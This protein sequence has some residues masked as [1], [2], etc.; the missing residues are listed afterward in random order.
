MESRNNLHILDLPFDVLH[1]I[2]EFSNPNINNLLK[3]CMQMW[4]YKEQLHELRLNNRASKLFCSDPAAREEIMSYLDKNARRLHL[5]L[6]LCEHIDDASVLENVH[7]LDLYSSWNVSDAFHFRNA[8]S[9]DLTNCFLVSDVSLLGNVY[10]LVLSGCYRI[11]DVSALGRVHTLDLSRC[12]RITD[13]S[14]LGG[15]HTLDLSYCP[16]FTDVSTLGRL[17]HLNL[18]CC[19]WGGLLAGIQKLGGLHTLDLRDCGIIK[20]VQVDILSKV[21]MLQITNTIFIE[22]N[23]D[24]DTDTNAGS[25]LDSNQ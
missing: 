22:D 14:A 3:T 15:V 1:I 4:M 25:E 11:D 2:H 17:H 10:N 21:K 19:N 6:H 7:S 12:P 20:G 24:P 8:H 23:T 13:V 5:D 9:L 18:R 16:N